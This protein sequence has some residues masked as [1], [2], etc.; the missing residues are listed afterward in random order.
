MAGFAVLVGGIALLSAAALIGSL[1]V[2]QTSTS[3]LG[4]HDV[5]LTIEGP[6]G[7]TFYIP[8]RPVDPDQGSQIN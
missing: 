4:K 7:H 8:L 6:R 5:W 1:Q 3:S 2:P